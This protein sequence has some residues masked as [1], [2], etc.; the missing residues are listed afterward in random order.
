MS[1]EDALKMREAEWP[2]A[3]GT[4]ESGAK[5]FKARFC[6]PGMR[7]SRQGAENLLPIRAAILSQRFDELWTRVYNSPLN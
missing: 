5:Q 3:S 4:V 2:I 7:W 1:L 6:G